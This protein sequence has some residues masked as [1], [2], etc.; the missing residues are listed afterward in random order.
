MY[1]NISNTSSSRS[2]LEEDVDLRLGRPLNSS[3]TTTHRLFLQN[4]NKSNDHLLHF[5]TVYEEC[6]N[7]E[8][9]VLERVLLALIY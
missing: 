2:T 1:K 7:R 3:P 4:N 6:M 8:F 9:F 5:E